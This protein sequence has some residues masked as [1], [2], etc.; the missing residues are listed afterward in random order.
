[1]T[2]SLDST[3]ESK[4]KCKKD[5]EAKKNCKVI[6]LFGKIKILDKLQEGTSTEAVG[7]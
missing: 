3:V 7:C 4:H 6:A 5:N 2:L 1:M